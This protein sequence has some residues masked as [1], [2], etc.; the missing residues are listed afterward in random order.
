MLGELSMWLPSSQAIEP[1]LISDFH[2]GQLMLIYLNGASEFAYCLLAP[3][4]SFLCSLRLTFFTLALFDRC[5]HFQSVS[6]LTLQLSP[7]ASL[8][9]CIPPLNASNHV[10]NFCL[11]G[12]NSFTC[13]ASPEHSAGSIKLPNGQWLAPSR[14]L[15][16]ICWM[17]EHPSILHVIFI[18]SFH[19]P[20]SSSCHTKA[21]EWPIANRVTRK[22]PCLISHRVQHVLPL[23]YHLCPTFPLGAV[24][25]PGPPH[26]WA[27]AETF[28][29]LALEPSVYPLCICWTA[30]SEERIWCHHLWGENHSAI[31]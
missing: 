25:S 8:L 9:T 30:I 19:L 27:T 26:S 5:P 14:D 17:C 31:L 13:I 23:G 1:A 24:L 15:M 7:Q 3:S 12:E 29:F 11:H 10:F 21:P 20:C 18:S 16:N 6:H 22:P 28:Q 2:V 4:S